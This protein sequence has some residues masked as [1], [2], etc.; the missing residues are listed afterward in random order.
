VSRQEE[1]ES[2]WEARVMRVKAYAPWAIPVVLT[3]L[4]CALLTP[5]STAL[6]DHLPAFFARAV[7]FALL[8]L[9]VLALVMVFRALPDTPAAA[10]LRQAPAVR[11]D[12]E[13]RRGFA[14]KRGVPKRPRIEPQLERKGVVVALSRRSVEP[15]NAPASPA[16]SSRVSSENIEIV[17]RR[18]QDR[19]ERLWRRRA[20]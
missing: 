6:A 18:L 16:S 7:G 4:L 13:F 12:S 3:A 20:G 9:A 1:R 19:A 2:Y 5:P 17:K 15:A 10:Q 8:G 11:R 14:G